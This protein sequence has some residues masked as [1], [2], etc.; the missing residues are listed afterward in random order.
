MNVLLPE[1]EQEEV[2]MCTEKINM[3][4]IRSLSMT[5]WLCSNGHKILKVEDSEKD[6]N[7]K[8]SFS[9]ADA[10][11]KLS[12]LTKNLSRISTMR[13]DATLFLRTLLLTKTERSTS[14]IRA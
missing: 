5:N 7:L 9:R 8:V 6:P 13:S 10:T 2:I 3:Y 14:L 12:T 1:I 4:I 11:Q